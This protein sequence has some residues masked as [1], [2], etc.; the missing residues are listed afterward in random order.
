[1]KRN[2]VT[3]KSLM[4]AAAV[5]VLV[6]TGFTS[7]SDDD[8][9]SYSNATV[10]NTEL[11][12][13]LTQKG[14]SFN[15][16]G[17]LLLD[18]MA[19]NTTSLD[20]SGTNISVDALSELNI[21]PNLTGVN[22]SD[23]GYGP[24]FDFAKLPAQVTGVDLTGNEI[25]D[26]DNLA[27]LNEDGNVNVQRTLV[28]LYLPKEAKEN[29]T[30]L[31]LFYYQNKEAVTNGSI[32]MKLENKQGQLQT[33]T[34]LRD[35]PNVALRTYLQSQFSNI[36][37]GEQIDITKYFGDQQANSVDVEPA[38]VKN[39]DEIT[40]LEGIQYIVMNPLWK[41]T[42]LVV[43]INSA[44]E[45]G[46]TDFSKNVILPRLKIGSNISKLKLR[47]VNIANELDL[48][49][50]VNIFNYWF[51]DVNLEALDLSKSNIWG[52]RGESVEFDE[53]Q[54]SI[55][56]LHDLPLLKE[57]TLPSGQ[58]FI[59]TIDL[60]C[61]PMLDKA[62]LSSIQKTAFI[63]IGDL[64][65]STELTYPTLVGHYTGNPINT[66]FGCTESAWERPETQAFI[67]TYYTDKERADRLA[68]ASPML[69]HVV[70]SCRWWR[71]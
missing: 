4:I 37:V 52:Q 16:Q 49:E 3:F 42:T 71:K 53:L 57:L 1:M 28:K 64:G 33:Y 55:L 9:P 36:F 8:G 10:Q 27:E 65:K 63:I 59:N 54:G 68:T 45:H 40:D 18:D 56:R 43:D 11:K 51:E 29:L 62:D 15:E 6:C 34:S 47:K 67:K 17:N 24:A 50:A 38:T 66:A 26:F 58:I 19:M 5:S 32:D 70:P 69:C 44:R 61:L 60:N 48:S 46:S 12:T 13:I 7:C 30:D 39:I 31:M 35:V 2:N 41:G 21:L 23:N 20:L 25:Y 14:Y 22:L